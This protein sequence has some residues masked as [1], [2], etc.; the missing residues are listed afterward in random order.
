MNF[1]QREINPAYKNKFKY[2]YFL[3]LAVFICNVQ[4]DKFYLFDSGDTITETRYPGTFS[5][6][7]FNDIFDVYIM[8]DTVDYL[9]IRGGSNVLNCVSTEIKNDTLSIDNNIKARWSRSYDRVKITVH[10][11]RLV[12]LFLWAPCNIKTIGQFAGNTFSVG[13]RGKTSEIDLDLKMNYIGVGI[14]WE[15]FDYIKLKGVTKKL[16]I[17]NWC[18]SR[19]IADSLIANEVNIT[20]ASI[21]DCYVNATTKLTAKLKSTGNIYYKGTPSTITVIEQSS[22][23]RLISME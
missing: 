6:I 11:T 2:F 7:V 9:D 13:C 5:T 10:S 17:D 14:D 22:D 21:A 12:R 15:S 3:L 23:G 4:C 1:F 20:N 19:V 18:S 8:N 16:S